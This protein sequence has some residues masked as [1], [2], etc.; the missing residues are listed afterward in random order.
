MLSST[1]L[2]PS[3]LSYEESTLNFQRIK[4]CFFDKLSEYVNIAT[5]YTANEASNKAI[6][7]LKKDTRNCNCCE[8]DF[9]VERLV[10]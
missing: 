8:D 7:W 4:T 6:D 9:F 10:N 2:T 5:I 1:N 3:L